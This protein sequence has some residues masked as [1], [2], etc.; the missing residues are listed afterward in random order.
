MSD[1]ILQ[2]P[3]ES[4]HRLVKLAVD[5]GE[6]ESIQE[7]I[8]LFSRY[9]VAVSIGS[10]AALNP[11]HQATLLTIVNIA[12]RCF[13]GG[14]DV[15]GNLDAPL[16]CALPIGN[17][18]REAVIGLGGN[19]VERVDGSIPFISV[20]GGKGGSRNDFSIR[21]TFDGWRVGVVPFNSD[22]RLNE[23]INF[24]PAGVLAGA[25]AVNEAFMRLRGNAEAGYR[26]IGLSLWK[27]DE[28]DSWMHS[29]S[30]GP[31]L[32]RLPSKLWLIGLGHL[33]QAYLWTLGL[34]P[35]HDPTCVELVLQDVDRISSST[36]STSILTQASMVRE[37]K[38]RTMAQWAENRG[39]KTTLLERLFDS[40]FTRQVDEPSVALCGLDNAIGRQALEDV[41][42]RFVV[43]AGLGR[44]IH[45]FR[46]I[47]LHTFPG[48]RRATDIW[49]THENEDATVLDQPA[50]H[51]LEKEGLDQCGLTMLAGKAIGA[52]FVGTVAAVLAICEI[53]RLLEG[54]DIY[55]M[56][57]VD[58]KS[59][60]HRVVA[61]NS[62]APLNFNPG[63]AEAVLK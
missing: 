11:T 36:E 24:A 23:K 57:D 32:T 63:F 62:S 55:S 17:S 41:G 39:F 60:K 48:H 61:I 7:A 45:D 40:S 4:L 42:F 22:F 16:T 28:I 21:T 34:L 33:G 18:L 1:T 10:A 6:A 12:R 25:L 26:H 15:V 31:P 54:G 3:S 59:L 13:L 46:S 14:V 2:D 5:T 37:M 30:D 20:G 43:E 38:T 51:V 58:L 9:R 56:I 49:R 50:Y 27:L 52:P 8:T 35:Y 19:L 53:I 44:G 29:S 47:R